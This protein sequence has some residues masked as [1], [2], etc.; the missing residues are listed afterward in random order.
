MKPNA[1]DC[2]IS[3][4]KNEANFGEC[5]SL[6]FFRNAILQNEANLA[7]VQ[8]DAAQAAFTLKPFGSPPIV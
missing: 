8:A 5:G 3:V 6:R 7:A 1:A 4:R 2:R